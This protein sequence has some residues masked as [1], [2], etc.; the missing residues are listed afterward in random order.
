MLAGLAGTLDADDCWDGAVPTAA[1]EML[2]PFE[3]NFEFLNI[4]VT[5]LA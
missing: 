5:G 1:R 3:S 2:E 4:L